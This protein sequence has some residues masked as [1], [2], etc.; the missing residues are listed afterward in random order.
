L[1]RWKGTAVYTKIKKEKQMLLSAKDDSTLETVGGRIRAARKARKLRIGAVAAQIGLSRTSLSQWEA[2][3]V[4]N[5]DVVKLGRF[6]KLV[7]VSLDWLLERKGDDPDLTP[8]APSGRRR[9]PATSGRREYD[10]NGSPAHSELPIAEIAAALTAHASQI[11]MTPR[12]FW[13]IPRQILEI[14]FNAQPETTVVKRIVTKKGELG[15]SRGDYVLI[16]ASRTRIDEA[17]TYLVA[18]PD[19]VSARCVLITEKNGKLEI[20]AVADDL[21]RS[22]PQ[23]AVENLVSLGRIMGIFK[24]A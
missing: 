17:G 2:G 12:S 15:L 5:P 14:G 13:T 4:K 8:A 1:A 24:P 10:T 11:D 16:D 21:N 7:D 23:I 9:I 19:K 20:A 22:C 3:A 18:D 6:V